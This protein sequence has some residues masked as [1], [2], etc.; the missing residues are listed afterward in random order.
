MD[1]G[2][3]S[4]AAPVLLANSRESVSNAPPRRQRRRGKGFTVLKILGDDEQLD[5]TGHARPLLS[6]RRA[7]LAAAVVAAV[8]VALWALGGGTR[9]AY[10]VVPPS[11]G[12]AV[13]A[14]YGTGD[15]EPVNW[16][17]LAT[18]VSARLMRLVV[19]EG[20]RVSKGQVLAVQEDHVERATLAELEARQRFYET[21]Y[22]RKEKLAT[23]DIV[24]QQALAQTRAFAEEYAAKV[25]AQKERIGLL[26]ITSPIDG[27]VLRRDGELGE[28]IPAGTTVLWVGDLTELNVVAAIDE[29]DIALVREGQKVLVKSDAQPGR[30]IA[31]TVARITPK[32]DPIA[33][34]FR[35]RVALPPDAGLM[36]GMTTEINIVVREERD[37]LLVP[38]TAVADGHVWKLVDGRPVRTPV[39]VGIRSGTEVQ[40]VKGLA[41][42][43]RIVRN[44]ATVPRPANGQTQ[45]PGGS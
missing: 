44:A 5:E 36:V 16:A 1:C 23:R 3:Y 34:T 10:D 2:Y 8:A 38:V 15:V 22:E 4:P 35:V 11:R 29:E 21:D 20:E 14:I 39:E 9:P 17:K 26:S 18:A 42:T 33:K 13:L 24:S 6:R 41:T 7:L 19:R 12:N 32:G 28:L 40:I 25:R 43:D 30:A 31:G 27:V 37:A 45:V